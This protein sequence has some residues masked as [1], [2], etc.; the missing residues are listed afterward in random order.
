[1]IKLNDIIKI[2]ILTAISES[3]EICEVKTLAERFNS[4]C[5]KNI[6]DGLRQTLSV[7]YRKD[8]ETDRLSGSVKVNASKLKDVLFSILSQNVR[9]QAIKNPNFKFVKEILNLRQDV[10]VGFMSGIDREGQSFVQVKD[11]VQREFR[12]TVTILEKIIISTVKEILSGQRQE[13]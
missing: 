13:T 10:N 7:K 5:H 12:D 8:K 9:G 3:R 2:E 1:M 4:V 6:I 11:S